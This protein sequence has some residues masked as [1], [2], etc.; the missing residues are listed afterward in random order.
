VRGMFSRTIPPRSSPAETRVPLGEWDDEDG[1]EAS[2]ARLKLLGMPPAFFSGTVTRLA[3][4]AITL[5][6]WPDE[7]EPD[8]HRMLPKLAG[9][10]NSRG[11]IENGMVLGRSTLE[12]MEEGGWGAFAKK[13]I[14]E[15]TLIANVCGLWCTNAAMAETLSPGYTM[16]IPEKMAA[17]YGIKK[18]FLSMNKRNNVAYVNDA[19][20]EKENN[21]QFK[22]NLNQG[23]PDKYLQLW[24]VKPIRARREICADYMGQHW[25][26]SRLM[27][28]GPALLSKILTHHPQLEE[29]YLRLKSGQG[30]AS[31]LFM[32]DEA[33][34]PEVEW[35][36]DSYVTGEGTPAYNRSAIARESFPGRGLP[37]PVVKPQN[38]S[39][40]SGYA[41]ANQE[42]IGEGSGIV[43]VVGLTA[44]EIFRKK[45]KAS[46]Q[47]AVANSVQTKTVDL[48][49]RAA[50][51]FGHFLF[52]HELLD[53]CLEDTTWGDSHVPVFDRITRLPVEMQAHLFIEYGNSVARS[54]R[55]VNGELSALKMAFELEGCPAPGFGTVMLKRSRS[56]FKTM[57]EKMASIKA[58]GGVTSEMMLRHIELH[59][60]GFPDTDEGKEAF[61]T[62]TA[63]LTAYD[64]GKRMCVMLHTNAREENRRKK[65]KPGGRVARGRLS[66][67]HTIPVKNVVLMTE[68]SAYQVKMSL[69][70]YRDKVRDG[71][72]EGLP[73]PAIQYI[74]F[75]FLSDKT[76][77]GKLSMYKRGESVY[78]DLVMT[79]ILEAAILCNHKSL[80]DNLFS[81]R[82][83]KGVMK[84][85]LGKH[86]GA[87]IKE[88]ARELGLPEQ[89]FAF[90]SL[91]HAFATQQCLVNSHYQ[92]PTED[93]Q[94]LAGGR[95]WAEGSMVR[96][97][98]YQGYSYADFSNLKTLEEDIPGTLICNAMA[99]LELRPVF[100][101]LSRKTE[102]YSMV[103][104][105]PPFFPIP[106]VVPAA[107]EELIVDV[108]DMPDGS[109]EEEED[110]GE[111]DTREALDDEEEFALL[112]GDW[113]SVIQ[114]TV[115]SWWS[116]SATCPTSEISN[117]GL[118]DLA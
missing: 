79:S 106:V 1:S 64:K 85:I 86:A 55:G 84:M 68:D 100:L 91:R 52:M 15:K 67:Y 113:A 49:Y 77:G 63:I 72:A 94:N 3:S 39:M 45:T 26:G 20:D 116:S 24:S 51:G 25:G 40:L 111:E 57:N 118:S 46:V 87:M 102:P 104:E 80:L 88:R 89:S 35:L 117:G 14:P 42:V 41:Q 103:G 12:T 44:L 37:A 73:P 29:E 30:N 108:H 98:F 56:G 43:D 19:L 107:G 74:A 33:L 50:S 10:K 16:E 53:L 97:N 95:E 96:R 92:V 22:F 5:T 34:D 9:F 71:H 18:R 83:R 17:T 48:A 47:V 31:K 93:E 8:Q 65:A 81:Y 66:T 32:M 61:L 38:I 2:L 115:S 110:L 114:R 99:R 13:D 11:C 58:K 23:D 7:E 54:G 6:E 105:D 76:P 75:H 59:K 112:Q 82:T 36:K 109:D 101:E 69:L 4:G 78:Q 70:D 90:H 27:A 60:R 21:A 62:S 28:A